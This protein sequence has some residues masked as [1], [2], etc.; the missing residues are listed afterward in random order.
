MRAKRGMWHSPRLYPWQRPRLAVLAAIGQEV[1]RLLIVGDDLLRRV[2][3]DGVLVEVGEVREVAD[4]R[5]LVHRGDVGA[6]LL[7]RLDAVE[8][9]GVMVVDLLAR[10]RL[11]DGLTGG[12]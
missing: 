3:G 5:R 12:V 11:F 6:R 1:H 4:G 9:V 10:L 8:P 2:P 7:A